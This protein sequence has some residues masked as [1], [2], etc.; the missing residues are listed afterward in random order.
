[1]TAFPEPTVSDAKVDAVV[2]SSEYTPELPGQFP[3]TTGPNDWL[4][5]KFE[6]RLAPQPVKLNV[7]FEN[8]GVRPV[9]VVTS[10]PT[11]PLPPVIVQIPL[12]I[13][14]LRVAV[15]V[16]E[17]VRKVTLGLLV[18]KASVPVKAPAVRSL[19][20]IPAIVPSGV[21]VPPPELPSKVMLSPATGA[22]APLAP[23]ELDA[24]CVVV[25]LSQVPVPPTQNL[26]AASALT[27]ARKA[28]ARRKRPKRDL[29]RPFIC[30]PR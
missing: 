11:N 5:P 13:L 3:I 6:R 15:P 27:G 14:M 26:L 18:L 25:V 4:V 24:Q 21:T 22:D 20:A 17:T 2:T 7:A 9:V 8:V 29:S 28:S 10:N 12:P 1:M 19:K 23:P 16:N 30:R